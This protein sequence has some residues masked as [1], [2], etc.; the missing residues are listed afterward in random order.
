M[1][2]AKKNK[3]AQ[4]EAD[5]VEQLIG[6]ARL[7]SVKFHQFT[8]RHLTN[9][10]SLEGVAILPHVKSGHGYR[11]FPEER[12]FDIRVD[13]HLSGMAEDGKTELIELTCT[14]DLRYRV[15]EEYEGDLSEALV[16]AF[17]GT[18]GKYN[19]WPY[20]REAFQSLTVRLGLQPFTLPLMRIVSGGLELAEEPVPKIAEQ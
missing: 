3:A 11:T 2:K 13:A 20:M 8:A 5:E 12:M 9:V 16:D 1:P 7:E 14:L 17:G 4:P 19:A 6:A 18:N 10:P 15:T